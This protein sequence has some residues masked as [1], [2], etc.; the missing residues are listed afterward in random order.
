MRALTLTARLGPADPLPV[1][2]AIRGVALIGERERGATLTE[3]ALALV[4]ALFHEYP[5][6]LRLHDFTLGGTTTVV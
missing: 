5:E 4:R 3:F 6:A 1:G 2:L